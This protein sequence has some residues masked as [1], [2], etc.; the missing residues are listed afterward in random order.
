MSS[1]INIEEIVFDIE[2]DG[3]SDVLYILKRGETVVDRVP[4]GLELVWALNEKGKIVGITIL[5]AEDIIRQI[6]INEYIEKLREG[7]KELAKRLAGNQKVDEVLQNIFPQRETF[8]K[9]LVE[10]LSIPTREIR[11]IEQIINLGDELLRIWRIPLSSN[12]YL[13]ITIPKYVPVEESKPDF[14]PCRKC[15]EKNLKCIKIIPEGISISY[16]A[17]HNKIFNILQNTKS[18][19]KNLISIIDSVKEPT[20]VKEEIVSKKDI[21]EIYLASLTES[22]E[23]LSTNIKIRTSGGFISPKEAKRYLQLIEQI[24]TLDK[25]KINGLEETM[26][27]ILWYSLLFTRRKRE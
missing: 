26:R 25:T 18:I 1:I 23:R 8:E 27:I 19:T 3:Q 4:C 16:D 24:E 14:I 21:T 5:F 20:M 12:T 15:N 7:I 17:H 2:Y 6:L 22:L 10:K 13:E 11:A 9:Q